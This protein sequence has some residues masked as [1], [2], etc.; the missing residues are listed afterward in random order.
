MDDGWTDDHCQIQHGNPI[1]EGQGN[2]LL[3]LAMGKSLVNSEQQEKT[4]CGVRAGDRCSQKDRLSPHT[5]A[6]STVG[7]MI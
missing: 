3:T 4:V 7:Q 6:A 2:V 1:G 5:Q